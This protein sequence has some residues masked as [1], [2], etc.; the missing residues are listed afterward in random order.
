MRSVSQIVQYSMQLLAACL[1]CSMY[2]GSHVPSGI[3]RMC[4]MTI[5]MMPVG[6]SALTLQAQPALL[7]ESMAEER[8]SCCRSSARPDSNRPVVCNCIIDYIMAFI[9][10]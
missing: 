3:D 1:L 10:R 6:V 5:V 4:A 7:T 9:C 2:A 8:A